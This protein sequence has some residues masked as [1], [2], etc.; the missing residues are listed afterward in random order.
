MIS[1]LPLLKQFIKI[2]SEKKKAFSFLKIKKN[3][4]NLVAGA[5]FSN[6]LTLNS[7]T[8]KS[9]LNNNQIDLRLALSVTEIAV[10]TFF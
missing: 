1:C 6:W 4:L 8:F 5:Q 7:T 10:I 2:C 9:N 3:I